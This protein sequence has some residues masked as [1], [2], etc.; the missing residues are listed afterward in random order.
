MGISAC[1]HAL[2]VIRAT[3]HS[4]VLLEIGCSK[5]CLSVTEESLL[6]VVKGEAA[7]CFIGYTGKIGGDYLK[8]EVKHFPSE[9][10]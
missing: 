4:L 10:L 3:G 8:V 1:A 5:K 7:K 2:V 6:N 9:L